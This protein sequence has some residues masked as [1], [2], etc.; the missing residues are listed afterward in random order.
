M[1]IMKLRAQVDSLT[2][3]VA[4]RS[5]EAAQFSE[6]RGIMTQAQQSIVREVR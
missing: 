3:E 5:A 6:M 2:T 1:Q 4:A